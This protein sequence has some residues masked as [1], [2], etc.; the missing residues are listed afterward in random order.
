MPRGD[1]CWPLLVMIP[2]EEIFLPHMRMI[3][4][5][6]AGYDQCRVPDAHTPHLICAGLS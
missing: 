2:L 5:M 6:H 1:T 3:G 4:P